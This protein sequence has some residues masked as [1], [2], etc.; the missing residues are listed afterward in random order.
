[1]RNTKNYYIS[2]LLFLFTTLSLQAQ[3]ESLYLEGAVPEVDGKVTFAKMIHL[4]GISRNDIYKEVYSWM[5]QS[6]DAKNNQS[7][8]VYS[9]NEPTEDEAIVVGV[10]NDTIVFKS[11]ILSLD[12]TLINYQIE[13][14]I[15]DAE[16]DLQLTRIAYN[17][18]KDEKYTA[19]EMISD[20]AAL[21]KAKTKIYP[22]L[23]KWRIG[24]I[25]FVNSVFSDATKPLSQLKSTQT[26]I[27][28]NSNYSTPK[29]KVVEVS[30]YDIN[31]DSY[32]KEPTIYDKIYYKN[33]LCRIEI[34][35]DEKNY[36]ITRFFSGL[37]RFMGIESLYLT[38]PMSDVLY[39]RLE[40]NRQFTLHFYQDEA[41]N[42]PFM[43]VVC[44]KTI[45]QSIVP[46]SIENNALKRELIKKPIHKLYINKIISV[47]IQSV[48]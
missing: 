2:F 42:S 43:T 11:T 17:Y 19:E 39:D 41:S 1:M 40:S 47:N 6:L 46:E 31:E 29:E 48:K 14:R 9:V 10:V 28:K 38:V 30:K 15:K 37:G 33:R 3:E 26:P 34:E 36:N 22:G 7:R 21:N 16:C 44:E 45:A 18:Q 8:V 32:F 12:R 4:P 27:N 35:G 20:D 25:D 5:K 24:T 23:K 13:A